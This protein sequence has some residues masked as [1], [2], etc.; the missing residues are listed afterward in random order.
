MDL[1]AL[2]SLHL[3][4]WRRPFLEESM[5]VK[6]ESPAHATIMMFGDV[7]KLMLKMMGTTGTIPAALT[8]EEVPAALQRL[9]QAV[10]MLPPSE[11]RDDSE[12][13]DASHKEGSSKVA[14]A[15]RAFPLI[16][17]L[18][19]AARKEKHVMWEEARHIL[20]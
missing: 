17:L 4:H 6:F 2:K 13:D 5:L 1:S 16:Q 10:S 20:P 19:A 7:A 14:L 11:Q 3:V 15:K 9:K 8:A 12:E 18:E